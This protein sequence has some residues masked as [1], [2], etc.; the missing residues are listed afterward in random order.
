MVLYLRKVML[1]DCSFVVF[2]FPYL[3]MSVLCYLCCGNCLSVSLLRLRG[4]SV[5][6]VVGNVCLARAFGVTLP[7]LLDDDE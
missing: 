3:L 5:F 1:C 4:G 7:E 2:I 6:L